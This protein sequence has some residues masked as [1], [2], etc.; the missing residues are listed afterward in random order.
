MTN[1]L[2]KFSKR[3]EQFQ[4]NAKKINGNNQVPFSELFNQQFMLSHTGN[5]YSSFDDFLKASKFSDMPFEE[6]PDDEW[7]KWV[8]SQ[9]DFQSWKDMKTNAGQQWVTKQLGF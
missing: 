5:Q 2:D 6:I 9:T 4:K 3:L 8:S 7:G 1:D